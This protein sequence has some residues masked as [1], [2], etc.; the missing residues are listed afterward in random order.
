MSSFVEVMQRKLWL[1][2]SG[3]S[4]NMVDE[5]SNAPQEVQMTI[6]VRKK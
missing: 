4:V 2:F 1:L 5:V 3:R 6:I